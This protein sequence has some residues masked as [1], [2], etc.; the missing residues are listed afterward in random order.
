[1]LSMIGGGFGEFYAPATLIVSGDA[2]ATAANILTHNA[3]FRW[4]FAAYMLEAICDIALA[5]IMYVILRPVHKDIAL[6]AAFFGLVSTAVFA[7]AELF[8][9]AATFILGGADYL[10]TFSPD[11]I[12]TLGL[13]SLK[14]YGFGAGI[15]MAFYGSATLIRGYLIYRSTFLPRF[16]GVLLMIAGVGFILKN[17]TLVVA[18]T[19]S[20]DLLLLPVFVSG[21]LL[22]GWFLTKGVDAAKWEARAAG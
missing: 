12:N 3:M 8:Y 10:N 11:Q 20:S 17:F 1:M 14:F 7:C 19:Y 15:F 21:L 6:L 18:P 13:L 4:G 2:G 22:T 9:F 16:L 5:W